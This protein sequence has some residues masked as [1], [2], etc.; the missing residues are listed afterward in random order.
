MLRGRYQEELRDYIKREFKDE[1]NDR[2]D[3]DW[4][5]DKNV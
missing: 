2:S 4:R 3:H 5:S 1:Y